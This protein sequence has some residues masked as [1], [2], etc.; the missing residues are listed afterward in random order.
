MRETRQPTT[1]KGVETMFLVPA[2]ILG[3]MML[4]LFTT[5]TPVTANGRISRTD[6][7]IEIVRGRLARGEIDVAEYNRL[8]TGLTRPA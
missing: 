1:R 2:L 7:A 4:F 8:V 3:V 6:E 5:A